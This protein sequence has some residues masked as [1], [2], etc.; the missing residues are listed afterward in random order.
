M[1]TVTAVAKELGIKPGTLRYWVYKFEEELERK[2]FI[3][4]EKAFKLTRYYVLVSPEEF[5]DELHRL[6]QER[7]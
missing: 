1:K 2:G 6:Q 7:V 5:I 4:R 3:K